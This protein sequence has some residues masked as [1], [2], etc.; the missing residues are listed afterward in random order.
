MIGAPVLYIS[1]N[2]EHRLFKYKVPSLPRFFQSIYRKWLESYEDKFCKRV[3]GIVTISS[4]DAKWLA[5][6]NSRVT[7]IPPSFAPRIY[8]YSRI[9]SG[10]KLII[11]FLG[12]E[13]WPPNR[14]AID[15]LISQIIPLTRRGITLIIAGWS[16][17]AARRAHNP[18]VAGSNPAPAI[19]MN[20]TSC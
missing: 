4:D 17:L 16:S 18:K 11:G 3:D 12:A 15:I 13:D 9:S 10:D 5:S 14:E 19:K 1:H 8:P 6:R 20:V 7:I 2:I